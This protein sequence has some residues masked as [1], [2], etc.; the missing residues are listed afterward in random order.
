MQNK[1]LIISNL[2]RQE[3]ISLKELLLLCHTVLKRALLDFFAV[4]LSDPFTA[5][6]FLPVFLRPV[7]V[8]GET[9]SQDK[10]E[11]ASHHNFFE[12]EFSLK[13][14]ASVD[15]FSMLEQVIQR[16]NGSGPACAE[17]TLECDLC[18]VLCGRHL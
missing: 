4:N 5:E 6:D 10:A 9:D 16:Q 2:A 3:V 15:V 13:F 7:D 17:L 18:R 8:N 11:D 12:V 14:G 1:S